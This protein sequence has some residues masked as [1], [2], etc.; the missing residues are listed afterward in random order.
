VRIF[1]GI[2]LEDSL[3][4]ACG[5]AARELQERLR[6]A[7]VNLQVRWI[8]EHNLHITLW[9]LGDVNDERAAAIVERLRLRW[10]VP[11]FTLTAA[12]AGAFPASGPP[13]IVWLGVTGGA[14]RMAE[15]Y[16]E[17]AVRLPALGFEAERRPYSPHIS[18]GRVKEAGRSAARARSILGEAG[19]H[20][21]SCRIGAVT[22]FQSRL[23]PAGARYEPLLR[24]PLE[25]C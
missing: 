9:F 2:E 3:K 24:V 20:P 8:P 25:E 4:A 21:G 17:L 19:V 6:A 22:L 12:G 23:S 11:P 7:R 5:E 15:L 13:R 16:Q 1:I 10:P 14:K 18:I